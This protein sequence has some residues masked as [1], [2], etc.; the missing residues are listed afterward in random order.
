MGPL[1]LDP[2]AAP[3][4]VRRV[5]RGA[6]RRGHVRGRRGRAGALRAER[7]PPL[8]RAGGRALRPR[9]ASLAPVRRWPRGGGGTAGGAAPGRAGGASA[10]E[11]QRPPRPRTA[12]EPAAAQ[13]LRGPRPGLHAV[14][15]R[16]RHGRRAPRRAR[17][18]FHG[19]REHRPPGLPDPHLRARLEGGAR[20][21]RCS[22][23]GRSPTPATADRFTT[24]GRLAGRVRPGGVRRAHLLAQGAR[25]PQGDRAAAP[26]R[27]SGSRSRSTSIPATSATARRSRPTAGRWSTRARPSPARSS[28][29]TTCRDRAQSSRSRR[30]ST[31]RRTAGGSA[32]APCVTWRPG[33]PVL[34]Q[35][36]GFSA[37]LPVG[38]GL[39]AFTDLD[40]AVEGAERIA[41]DY[42]HH[43]RAARARRGGALRLG[44]RAAPLSRGSGISLDAA[45]RRA[46]ARPEAPRG[47]SSC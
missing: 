30:A 23:S 1:E 41:A 47:R 26:R 9:G 32:T 42:E 44:Q 25:V 34:V 43:R 2:G 3:P 33:R 6:D 29:A 24:I 19:G 46:P 28:S 27:R 5:V 18:A 10:R 38:E 37:N 12:D 20:R 39:L 15:A 16:R 4:R 17:R 13:G 45:G 11:H 14:L 35:D 21:P 40:G 8:L 22:R 7:E 36:T 31:W